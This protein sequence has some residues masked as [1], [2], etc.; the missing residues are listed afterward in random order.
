MAAYKPEELSRLKNDKEP[1]PYA[2]DIF[3]TKTPHETVENMT[4]WIHET[5]QD[6]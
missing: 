4:Q 2:M 3:E 5:A 1:Q 6:V